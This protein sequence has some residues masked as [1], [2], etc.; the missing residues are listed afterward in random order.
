MLIDV[1]FVWL[2]NATFMFNPFEPCGL[3][4]SNLLVLIMDSV[5]R[6]EGHDNAFLRTAFLVPRSSYR[7]P[8]TAFLVP[9][10]ISSSQTTD[11]RKSRL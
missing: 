5:T 4:I 9:R 11:L 1:D 10:L 3:T 2:A 6:H 7:V 8:R